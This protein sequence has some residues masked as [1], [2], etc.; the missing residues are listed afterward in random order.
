ME[1]NIL[2]DRASAALKAVINFQLER[3][4]A[5]FETRNSGLANY[6]S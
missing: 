4:Q 3:P 1:V 5:A 2:A 6:V